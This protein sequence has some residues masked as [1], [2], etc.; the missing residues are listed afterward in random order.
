MTESPIDSQE[1]PAEAP[2]KS[3]GKII[4]L[5]CGIGFALAVIA[6][7]LAAV[8]SLL[9]VSTSEEAPHRLRRS[10]RAERPTREIE[11]F[12]PTV[13]S[14]EPADIFDDLEDT[15]DR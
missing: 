5:T 4:L 3:P 13:P 15:S 8:G 12:T 11:D 10:P 14:T 1:Q 7:T 6:V 2:S 9:W